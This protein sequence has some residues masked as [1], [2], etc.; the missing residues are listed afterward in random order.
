LNKTKNL[1]LL[2]R[3]DAEKHKEKAK[4]LKEQEIKR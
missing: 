2:K 4:R 3:D 1:E